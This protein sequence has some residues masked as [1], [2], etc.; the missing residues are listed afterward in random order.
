MGQR[1]LFDVVTCI[2]TIEHVGLGAYGEPPGAKDSDMVA[3]RRIRELTKPGGLLVLTVPL[4]E[5]GVDDVPDVRP[6]RAPGAARGLG[7]RGANRCPSARSEDMGVA[8]V[9]PSSTAEGAC[10]ALVTARSL[11]AY[12]W[13]AAPGPLVVHSRTSYQWVARRASATSGPCVPRR[14][15]S[16]RGRSRLRPRRAGSCPVD[17][18][19]AGSRPPA[20]V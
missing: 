4:G 12:D 11:L 8:E 15:R 17:E 6:C 18:R 14:R 9:E 3:M 5:A 10:V 13:A 2:S 19:S 1:Q 7:A 20:T 16:C